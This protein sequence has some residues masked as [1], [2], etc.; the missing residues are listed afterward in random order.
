MGMGS[1]QDESLSLVYKVTV[2]L[3]TNTVALNAGDELILRKA[4]AKSVEKEK[5]D[6][7]RTA[8][9]VRAQATAKAQAKATSKAKAKAAAGEL[10]V[11]DI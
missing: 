5:Y 9:K 2:P 3:M 10:D 7:W 8:I 6:D 1:W 4:E 11:L